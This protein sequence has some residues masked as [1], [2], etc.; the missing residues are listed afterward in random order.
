[1]N[2]L[3]CSRYIIVH[4]TDTGACCVDLNFIEWIIY[5]KLSLQEI[6]RKIH[7]LDKP[8]YFCITGQQIYTKTFDSVTYGRLQFNI[9]T[10]S[11]K[12]SIYKLPKMNK[13]RVNFRFVLVVSY[14]L[15]VTLFSTL[16]CFNN[17]IVQRFESSFNRRSNFTD[18]MARCSAVRS[19][20]SL[21]SA[22]SLRNAYKV[23]ADMESICNRTSNVDPLDIL[24]TCGHQP[25]LVSLKHVERS[26]KQGLQ[27]CF[28]ILPRSFE[29]TFHYHSSSIFK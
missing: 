27:A 6:N 16:L 4:K 14:V 18:V 17:N 24:R 22:S 13:H 29:L 19:F 2:W 7:N 20:Y 8:V 26:S 21:P 23:V 5:M 28:V 10:M 15:I 9:R 3:S 25:L 11:S 12:S 1:M